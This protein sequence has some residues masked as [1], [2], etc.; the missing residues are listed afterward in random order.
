MPFNLF[1][2]K[3]RM[4]NTEYRKKNI[5]ITG[6][7]SG[8]GIELVKLFISKGFNVIAT[9][10]KT[11]PFPNSE[12]IFS[13]F[14]VDFNDLTKVALSIK[15]ILQSV[16]HF[17][18]VINNAGVLSPPVF[19]STINGFE[20]SFQVNYLAHLLINEVILRE[21]KNYDPLKIVVV[22]SPVYRLADMDLT[23]P[24]E[25]QGYNPMKAYAS[26]KLYMTLMCEFLPG[27]YPGLDM[28]CFSFNPGT[29]RSGIYRMQKKWF[30][31]MYCVASPF[32]RGPDKVARILAEVISNGKIGNGMICDFRNHTRS[33]PSIE[34]LKKKAFIEDCYEQLDPILKYC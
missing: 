9:G 25:M 30:R 3:D 29:F 13:L 32:M 31:G 5:L 11:I 17:D 15:E 1:L 26:S 22:T 34:E 27:H 23:F 14:V 4:K 33:I 24:T 18:I 10:R 6:G 8:L 19:T 12:N 21:T 16:D 20:Y 7:T 2:K 28:N